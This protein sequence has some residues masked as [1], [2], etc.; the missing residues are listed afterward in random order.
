MREGN[1][2]DNRPGSKVKSHPSLL[3]WMPCDKRYRRKIRDGKF[4]F[5][6]EDASLMMIVISNSAVSLFE[7]GAGKSM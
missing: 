7:Y 6:A 4:W 2:I 5:V 3:V 1:V